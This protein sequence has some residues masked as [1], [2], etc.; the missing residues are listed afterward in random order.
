VVGDQLRLGGAHDGR[1][2]AGGRG[3]RAGDRGGGAALDVWRNGT[4]TTTSDSV[5]AALR[6]ARGREGYL[7][8][9]NADGRHKLAAL[10]RTAA[11]KRVPP[12][13]LMGYQ[14]ESGDSTSGFATL[15]SAIKDGPS[16][17]Y[18]LACIAETDEVRDTPHFRAILARIGTVQAPR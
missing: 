9:W 4:G 11:G 10:L 3:T 2:I 18:R 15:E 16:W 1:S 12:L 13:R 7:G 14:L 6:Y 17:I 8:A 5:A